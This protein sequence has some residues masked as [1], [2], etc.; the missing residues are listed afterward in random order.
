M[1]EEK[2][3]ESDHGRNKGRVKEKD[4]KKMMKVGEGGRKRTEGGGRGRE[5]KNRRR[6][7]GM[8]IGK[9]R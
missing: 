8:Q 4:G 1:D 9:E 6:K 2:D 3:K 5:E 7:K